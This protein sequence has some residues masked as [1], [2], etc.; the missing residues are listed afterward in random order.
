MAF[1]DA[2][3]ELSVAHHLDQSHAAVTEALSALDKL[4]PQPEV[5]TTVR[6]PISLTDRAINLE[7][8]AQILSTRLQNLV[9]RAGAAI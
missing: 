8:D 1:V 6:A 7:Q 4:D 5:P 2:P 3:A 9:N